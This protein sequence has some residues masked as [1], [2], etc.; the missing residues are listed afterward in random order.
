VKNPVIEKP[1]PVIFHFTP[2]SRTKK[3][4]DEGGEFEEISYSGP[5][6]LTVYGYVIVVA[7]VRGMGASYG[8][9]KAA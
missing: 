6:T 9:R 3:I 1:L 8:F 7:D 2:Y 4:F 5:I